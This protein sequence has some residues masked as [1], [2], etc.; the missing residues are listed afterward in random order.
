M[1]TSIFITF[2]TGLFIMVFCCLYITHYDKKIKKVLWILIIPTL[3]GGIIVYMIGYWSKFP[4]DLSDKVLLKGIITFLRAVFSAGRMFI[5]ENDYGDVDEVMQNSGAY[6]LAFS[7]VH[8]SALVIFALAA[9]SW[10]GQKFESRVKLLLKSFQTTYIIC[11]LNEYS[12]EF[13]KNIIESK[14]NKKSYSKNRVVFIAKDKELEIFDKVKKTDAIIKTEDYSEK[15]SLNG[16]GLSRNIGKKQI[17]F[18]AFTEDEALNINIA[19][20][21]MK[22]IK[23]DS[24]KQKLHIY[25][26]TMSYD[27][28]QVFD[29]ENELKEKCIDVRTFNE[30]NIASR[31]LMD[32]CPVYETIEIDSN[33][34]VAKSAFTMLILGFGEMGK[35]VLFKSICCSQFIGNKSRYIIVDNDIFKKKGEFN[36]RYSELMQKYDIK[37]INADVRQEKVHKM[38]KE[39]LNKINYIV[40][41]LGNDRLNV[42]VALQLRQ[43]ANNNK[44]MEGKKRWIAVN[45]RN[46]RETKRIPLD[47]KNTFENIKVFGLI[48]QIFTEDIVI[49]ESLDKMAQA[50]NTQYN[51]THNDNATPWNRLTIFGKES[52]RAAAIHIRTKLHMAGLAM[53]KEKEVSRDFEIIDTS[54]KFREYLGEIRLYNLSVCEH[55][56]WNAFH[57]VSGWSVWE[58]DD[59]GIAIKAK[60]EVHKRHACLVDWDKLKEVAVILKQEPPTYYQEADINQILSIPEVVQEAGEGVFINKS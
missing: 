53:N 42:D 45:V 1:I 35:Q 12:Y 54:E 31:Q 9:L 26:Y 57:F 51:N 41:V 39:N 30:G 38:L 59:V 46:E 52:N 4:K 29:R 11:G 44:L 22:R 18:I 10:F 28:E 7:I 21:L 24:I 19:L 47:E 56:R 5:V 8:S 55:L 33:E 17:Y 50:I 3:L 23:N 43:M 58:L 60:D 49:N 27:A 15:L 16:L 48:N 36:C 6:L 25:V 20:D 14:S 2:F 37:F 32:E 34:A 40:V 13:G